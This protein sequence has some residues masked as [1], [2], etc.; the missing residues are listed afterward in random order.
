MRLLLPDLRV[1]PSLPAFKKVKAFIDNGAS[2]DSIMEKFTDPHLFTAVMKSY[3]RELPD[4]LFSFKLMESWMAANDISNDVKRVEA[5]D[6]VLSELPEINKKNIEYLFDF[7]AKLVAEEATNKMS[8]MNVIV[9][10]GPNLLWDR[11]SK[12]PISLDNVCRSLIQQSAQRMLPSARCSAPQKRKT[13]VRTKIKQNRK[14]SLGAMEKPSFRTKMSSLIPV[15]L[16]EKLHIPS[17]NKVRDRKNE[18]RSDEPVLFEESEEDEIFKA[19][20]EASH[21]LPKVQHEEGV[22]RTLSEK[23]VAVNAAHKS[24]QKTFLA[25]SGEMA[26][27]DAGGLVEDSYRKYALDRL[28]SLAEAA[29]PPSLTQS[30][31]AI[32]TEENNRSRM[33]SL[34]IDTALGGLDDVESKESNGKTKDDKLRH[35]STQRTLTRPMSQSVLTDSSVAAIESQRR[36]RSNTETVLGMAVSRF[37]PQS[38]RNRKPQKDGQL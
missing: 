29:G 3:L 22:S 1:G 20:Q 30:G 34:G 12:K 38:F 33:S 14:V 8:V 36:T 7:L 35:I 24:L 25:S 27:A 19:S 32:T 5:V 37:S 4:P 6:R 23:T 9:V 13:E 16:N 28:D 17:H 15:G 21:K 31:L 18:L 26:E 10:V 2:E 11:E